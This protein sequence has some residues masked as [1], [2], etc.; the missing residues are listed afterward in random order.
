M[1]DLSLYL[2]TDPA[3]CG[4]RGVVEVVR[5]A[6]AGGVGIVQLRDKTATDAQIVEQLIELSG[7]IG[8]RAALVVNDRLDAAL[9]ARARG[10]RVD[11]VHLGQ[12]DTSVVRAREMLGPDAIIG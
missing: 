8:G 5:E 2:V 6:V 4:E 10:A 9:E 1:T 7:V 12:S 11:G 3:L